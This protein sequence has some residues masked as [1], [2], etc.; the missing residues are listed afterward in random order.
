MRPSIGVSMSQ[1]LFVSFQ[2]CSVNFFLLLDRCYLKAMN[3]EKFVFD[4]VQKHLEDCIRPRGPSDA[5][6]SICVVFLL[7]VYLMK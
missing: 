2:F 4:L 6:R 3:V 1:E 5:G 7:L